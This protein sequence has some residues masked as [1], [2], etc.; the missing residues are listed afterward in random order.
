MSI[1]FIWYQLFCIWALDEAYVTS[2]KSGLN[3]NALDL[4]ISVLSNKAVLD[5]R[6]WSR[7]KRNGL[8]DSKYAPLQ[9]LSPTTTLHQTSPG[10]G[11]KKSTLS[12]NEFQRMREIVSKFFSDIIV[13]DKIC[14]PVKMQRKHP[15]AKTQLDEL[16]QNDVTLTSV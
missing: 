10:G 2:W 11:R 13:T 6:D 5:M 8:G 14:F 1:S 16:N 4:L 7:K 3:F 15:L 12:N 9:S